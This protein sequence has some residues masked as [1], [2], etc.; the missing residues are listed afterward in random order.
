MSDNAAWV[1]IL[2]IQAA[3]IV[4][5]VSLFLIF[6]YLESRRREP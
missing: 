5:P 4:I 3:V 2:A 1:L 6:D